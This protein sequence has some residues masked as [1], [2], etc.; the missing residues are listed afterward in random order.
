[1][2][3]IGLLLIA[4][5]CLLLGC[6]HSASNSVQSNNDQTD[7]PIHD[8]TPVPTDSIFD[9]SPY[10]SNS[11]L[12][13]GS[14]VSLFYDIPQTIQIDMKASH[15]ELTIVGNN[16]V[17]V[18][19]ESPVTDS[20]GIATLEINAKLF[21]CEE[22]RPFKVCL[23]KTCE[24]DEDVCTE[25]KIN[26][27]SDDDVIDA[28][29]NLMFDIFETN[30]DKD[31][32]K[33][34]E[35]KPED[36]ESFCHDDDDCEDF[37]DSAIGYRCSTR[38]TRDDQCIKYKD[39][40]G[41]WAQ[42]VCRKDGRCAYPS[43]KAIYKI[44]KD[45]AIVT[46]DGQPADDKVTIDWGDG[47]IENIS[48]NAQ[49]NE[50]HH[51]YEK[52][53]T[54]EV[55]ITGDY[56]NWTAGCSVNDGIDLYD[57]WQ[58]GPI[59]L[60]YL[61]DYDGDD[62]GSFSN[63]Q[64]FNRMSARDIPDSTKLNNMSSMF[65]GHD[66]EMKFNVS[67]ITRWDTSNVTSMFHT[68]LNAGESSRAEYSRFGF[69][70]DIGRWNVSKVT[71][72]NGMFNS[73]PLFNQ[74]IGC[75]NMS[76]VDD[77]SYM[78]T[79]AISFNQDLSNW[80]LSKVTAHECVFR[81][82]NG[83][84]GAISFKN[85]CALRGRV[86][87]KNIGRDGDRSDKEH[88]DCPDI[89][90]AGSCFH[91]VCIGDDEVYHSTCCGISDYKM[92]NSDYNDKDKVYVLCDPGYNY[93]TACYDGSWERVVNECLEKYL[94]H[95]PEY[96]HLTED[97]VTCEHLRVCRD[98]YYWCHF[99]YEVDEPDPVRCPSQRCED[100]PEELEN[101]CPA[102]KETFCEDGEVFDAYYTG[103]NSYPICRTCQHL[104]EINP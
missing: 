86:N 93:G 12:T 2:K 18:L 45:G 50:V 7:T 19:T 35:Y 61:G 84:N 26:T 22:S 100:Y 24:T 4:L 5:S 73:A 57:I 70:Q 17:N 85:Y 1:M 29:H 54:Y 79:W 69:N 89:L 56:R 103:A 102:G 10:G 62:K 28:N 87:N 68:F 37:C 6:N 74:N 25:I 64:N 101:K 75:W 55:E 15:A 42:M 77:I 21:N 47:T 81:Y 49:R 65:A 32:Y 43:F 60:G 52:K 23:A 34:A 67:A 82:E 59:G 11:L 33:F 9:G 94:K 41:N 76:N 98:A 72:M 30:K 97:T 99:C 51:T 8:T 13:D 48:A 66:V 27:T 31:K 40:D 92:N 53:G 58:F 3:K 88:G 83:H 44:S 96:E 90:P 46:M 38:C 14:E 95:Q 36:C 16:C 39:D 20:D 104:K 91:E 71:N 80:D 78:F 63:C